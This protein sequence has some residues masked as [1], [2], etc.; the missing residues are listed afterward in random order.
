MRG[1]LDVIWTRLKNYRNLG[2]FFYRELKPGVRVIYEKSV[3]VSPPDERVLAF[4][5]IIA[6]CLKPL[7]GKDKDNVKKHVAE[8]K[9][10]LVPAMTTEIFQDKWC[11]LYLPPGDYHR[12]HSPNNWVV[13]KEGTLL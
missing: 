4:G 5:Y 12:F 11:V 13:E 1:Y 3:L 2:A 7:I 9:R 6:V 8:K 10:E